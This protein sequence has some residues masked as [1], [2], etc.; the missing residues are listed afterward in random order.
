MDSGL[1]GGYQEEAMQ[2]APK[3]EPIQA[4]QNEEKSQKEQYTFLS[5][6]YD[7][8]IHRGLIVFVVEQP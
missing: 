3:E 1:C 5:C 6:K 4:A 8:S 2:F 7:I